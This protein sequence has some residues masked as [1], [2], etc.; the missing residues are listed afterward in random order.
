MKNFL[1]SLRRFAFFR[2]TFLESELERV[3]IERDSEIE[4]LRTEVRLLMDTLLAANGL[5]RLN[6]VVHDA[7]PVTKGG[8]MLPS[9][10][11]R[12][13][14]QMSEEAVLAKDKAQV[15]A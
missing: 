8:R 12:K 2:L 9:Q 5:P 4:R 11:K 6:P 1:T 10:F 14:E 3:R 13:M 15:G 7:L